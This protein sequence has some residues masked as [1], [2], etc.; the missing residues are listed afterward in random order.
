MTT[1]IA[2]RAPARADPAP[3]RPPNRLAEQ[4]TGRSYLSHSQLSMMRSCPRK[5]AFNYVEHAPK[6]FTPSSLLFGG[7][8]HT[9]LELYYRCWLEGLAVTHEALLSAYHDSWRRQ[10]EQSGDDVPVRFN[11]GEDDDKLHVLADRMLKAFAASPLATPKGIILG[12]EEELRVVLDPTLP[13]VLAKVDLVTQ[14]A[15]GLHVVD[16]KTSKSRWNEH[17]AAESGDQLVL[18]GVTVSRM[19]QSL[20]VPVKLHFAILTK[21]KTPLV[22]ILPVPTDT[23]R[24]AAMKDGVA[25]V[26]AAIQSGNYY[27]SPSPMNCT[28]CPY[29]SRCPVFAGR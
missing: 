29:R 13:D 1:A 3:P 17:K 14:T 20:G 6:D 7:S 19:S 27:P 21:H 15:D 28:G 5:F 25:E 16:F 26:W 8:I 4:I 11:V 10:N 9:A 24:V 18:Y 2:K 22:Q 23:N 12:I